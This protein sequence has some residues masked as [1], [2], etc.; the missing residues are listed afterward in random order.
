MSLSTQAYTLQQKDF[1]H[2]DRPS[3]TREAWG[4]IVSII[5]D[6]SPQIMQNDNGQIGR[7]REIHDNQQIFRLARLTY[8]L[9]SNKTARFCSLSNG[10]ATFNSSI[11]SLLPFNIY[12]FTKYF[13]V[14]KSNF[15]DFYMKQMRIKYTPW[16]ETQSVTTTTLRVFG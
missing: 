6:L 11:H 8:W 13:H 9:V 10:S 2:V 14:N 15:S 16:D 5:E 1:L 12:S 3:T 4:L 7:S